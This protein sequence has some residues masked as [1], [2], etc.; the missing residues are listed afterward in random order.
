MK[1]TRGWREDWC[2]GKVYLIC[3]SAMPLAKRPQCDEFWGVSPVRHVVLSEPWINLSQDLLLLPKI[4]KYSLR[5]QRTAKHT[6]S[7]RKAVNWRH[8]RGTG[9]SSYT[10]W[11]MRRKE[12]EEMKGWWEIDEKEGKKGANK[13]M[14]KKDRT[15]TCSRKCQCVY[16][17]SII[18]LMI[19]T[20]ALL[21]KIN[22]LTK[23]HQVWTVNQSQV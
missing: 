23:H 13:T 3:S 8:A 20:H 19:Q 10:E 12:K 5:T 6:T 21:A 4:L 18:S 7:Q 1:P 14:W 9:S 2:E 22:W 15:T 17:V 16:A 11:K